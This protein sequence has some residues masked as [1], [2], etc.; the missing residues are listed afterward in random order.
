MK[1]SLPLPYFESERLE[2]GYRQYHKSGAGETDADGFFVTFVHTT[3][4]LQNYLHISKL[5]CTFAP[6]YGILWLVVAKR[7]Y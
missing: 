6:D 5:F 3:A 2:D 4:K 7:K 1:I